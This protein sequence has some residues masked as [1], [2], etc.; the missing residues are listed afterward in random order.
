MADEH[1]KVA[2]PE[3]GA[4]FAVTMSVPG[5]HVAPLAA[6]KRL[7]PTTSTAERPAPSQQGTNAISPRLRGCERSRGGADRRL[8]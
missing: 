5:D 3:A 7:P 4:R 2:S 1:A 8:A 6:I